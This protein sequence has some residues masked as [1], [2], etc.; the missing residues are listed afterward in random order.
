MTHPSK[1][2]EGGGDSRA[3]NVLFAFIFVTPKYVGKYMYKCKEEERDGKEKG[4][5]IDGAMKEKMK[6]LLTIGQNT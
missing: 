3:M 2:L 6:I 1:S 4:Q 5:K